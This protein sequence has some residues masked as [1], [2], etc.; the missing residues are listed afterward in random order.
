M[1]CQAKIWLV[2][3]RCTICE[4]LLFS[5]CIFIV[6]FFRKQ[7]KQQ[8]LF[9]ILYNQ[10]IK[11]K[12]FFFLCSSACFPIVIFMIECPILLRRTISIVVLF[13]FILVYENN[14]FFHSIVIA[15][16]FIYAQVFSHL[17][18]TSLFCGNNFPTYLSYLEGL[19]WGLRTYG[20]W[21]II[22]FVFH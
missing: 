18:I 15:L 6:L 12:S 17:V 14:K 16:L 19:V 21:F 13:F 10:K 4:I 22:P 3:F 11:G 9:L 1:I 7:Y 2:S 8:I 20:N 5:L